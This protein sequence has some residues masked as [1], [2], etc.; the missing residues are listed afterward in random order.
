MLIDKVHS[1]YLQILFNTGFISFAVFI[2][3]LGLHVIKSV[4]IFWKIRVQTT[5]EVL[6]L[7]F[8]LGWTGFLGASLF[9]DS[10]ISVSPY[11]WAV[12]GASVAANYVIRY[13]IPISIAVPAAGVRQKPKKKAKKPL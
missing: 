10:A 11:F 6:G 7:C 2:L 3:L 1:M 9:N 5:I 4:Q 12:F 13:P 8:F